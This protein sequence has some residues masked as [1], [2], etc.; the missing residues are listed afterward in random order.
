MTAEDKL[1]KNITKII[2]MYF[3]EYVQDYGD[4]D[5]E[6]TLISAVNECVK[7]AKDYT[8]TIVKYYGSQL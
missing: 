1:H 6:D 2:Y 8:N 3:E 5:W 4:S 7:K